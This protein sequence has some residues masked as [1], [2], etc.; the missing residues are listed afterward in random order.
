MKKR[1]MN[2]H[3]RRIQGVFLRA[4]VDNGWS[5]ATEETP[6]DVLLREEYDA[7][8]LDAVHAAA[9]SYTW[10]EEALDSERIELM[11]LKKDEAGDVAAWA[12]RR[13]VMWL[14]GDGLHPQ[15]LVKRLYVLL[16]ARYQEFLGPLNM[17]DLGMMLD[18]GRAAVSARME[19]LFT[20]EI[21]IK[22]GVMMVS[23]GMKDVKSKAKYAA[24]AK[25]H[26]PRRKKKGEVKLDAGAEKAERA[27]AKEAWAKKKQ[28][29]WE[30][31]ERKRIAE[32]VGCDPSE[33]DLSKSNPNLND[34]NDYE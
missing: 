19:R 25:K 33:I 12:R 24:N 2:D 23:P 26:A 15:T 32:L 6:L 21:M 9:G 5:A 31:Y 27:K 11:A 34:D 16:Y 3:E 1:T 13:L 8:E 22:T 7:D 17:T 4:W 29:Q 30:A 28:E 18:E 14:I 20:R 10:P